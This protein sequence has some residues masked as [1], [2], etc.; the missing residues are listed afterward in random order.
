MSAIEETP[1]LK[2]NEFQP[3]TL[4]PHEVVW[5]NRYAWLLSAGYRLRERYNPDWK[6]SWI[7]TAKDPLDCEDAHPIL[8]CLLREMCVNSLIPKFWQF[9]SVNH[10]TRVATGELVVLKCVDHSKFPREIEVMKYL[11]SE[12][13]GTDPRNHSTHPIDILQDP[14]EDTLSVIAIPLLRYF[15][16]P[17]FETMGEVL[18]FILQFLTV[19]INLPFRAQ[20]LT[21]DRLCIFCTRTE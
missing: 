11:S 5:R 18:D 16:D 7:G 8:V 21:I 6:P 3:E 2:T 17:P 15:Y 4:G 9:A 13:L 14:D 12:P 10:A 20:I 1:I 19:W